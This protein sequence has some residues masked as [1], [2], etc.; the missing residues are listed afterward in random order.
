MLKIINTNFDKNQIYFYFIILIGLFFRLTASQLGHH[1]TDI[2]WWVF[3]NDIYALDGE[4]YGTGVNVYAPGFINILKFLNNLPFF[5][6]DSLS[7]FRWKLIIFL[8]LI[9]CLIAT[10]LYRGFSLLITT[11]FFLNP[12]SIFITGF[13]NQF[14]NIAILLGLS[15]V[16]AYENDKNK[17]F[18]FS[19]FLIG[20][21]LII[22]HLLF[23]FPIWLAIK[24]Q[25]IIRKFLIIFIPY[26]IF[27]FSFAPFL[28]DQFN[29]ILADVFTYESFGNGPFWSIFTPQFLGS[30]I[31]YKKLFIIALLILGFFVD[32]K[33]IMDSFL[34]YTIALVVFSSAVA[35]QYLAIPIIAIAVYWNPYF[36]L[37]T[38]ACSLFFLVNHDALD[39]E[40]IKEIIN[41]SRKK[42]RIGY[43]VIIFFLTIGLLEVILSK[44]ILNKFYKKIYFWILT[45]FK[46]QINFK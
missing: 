9:D 18:Y 22:K 11:L 40:S 32:K 34:I 39:I 44:K 21:S 17:G 12:I 16:L 2:E 35:N 43:K 30:Y 28:P 38:I 33:N 10:I 42:A 46:N 19:A 45:K 7:A 37:Y 36:L 3:I 8:T 41:Y 15:A 27:L 24:E 25:K 20:F 29:N 5:A 13:H 1:T 31:G 6:M 26:T 4:F 14:D 23:I